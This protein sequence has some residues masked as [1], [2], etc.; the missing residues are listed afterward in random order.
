MLPGASATAVVSSTSTTAADHKHCKGH[1]DT[2]CESSV[3]CKS[4]NYIST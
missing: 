3:T 4:M 1:R 2:R